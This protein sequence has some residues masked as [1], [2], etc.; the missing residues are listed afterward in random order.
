MPR[1]MPVLGGH[2]M[3][4]LFGKRINNGNDFISLPHRK[5]PARAEIVLDVDDEED[6]AVLVELQGCLVP[7]VTS[8]DLGLSAIA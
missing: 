6:V 7:L 5:P 4:E 3:A 1:R 8:R 2:D